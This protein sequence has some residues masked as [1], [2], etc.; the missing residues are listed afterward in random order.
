MI[1]LKSTMNMITLK[2][3]ADRILRSQKERAKEGIFPAGNPYGYRA[4]L[5]AVDEKGKRRNGVKEIVEKEALVVKR[6]FEMYADGAGS[7]AI[8]R[9][10]NL[11]GIPF[12]IW[13]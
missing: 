8:A 9:R 2:E 1:G 3:T 7:K 5:D 6:I 12:P 10:L 13:R 4:K 11:E